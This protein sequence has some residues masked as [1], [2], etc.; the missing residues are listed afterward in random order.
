[1]KKILLS[2]ILVFTLFLTGCFTPKVSLDGVYVDKEVSYIVAYIKDDQQVG[3]AETEKTSGALLFKDPKNEI[4]YLPSLD[5][6]EI[7]DV[8]KI[9]NGEEV[10]TTLSEYYNDVNILYR[11]LD[12]IFENV[13]EDSISFDEE[14]GNYFFTT[15]QETHIVVMVNENKSIRE[16]NIDYGGGRKHIVVFY[17]FNQDE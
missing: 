14:T 6:G 12:N 17:G 5:E 13:V 1:M 8:K 7:Y 10:L 16:M 15:K 4:F 9:V 3:W 11:E 2:L